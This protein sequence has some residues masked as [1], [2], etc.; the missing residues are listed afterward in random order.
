[1]QGYTRLALADLQRVTDKRIVCT[2]KLHTKVTHEYIVPMTRFWGVLSR[3]ELL[4][5]NL[6][7]VDCNDECVCVYIYR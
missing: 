2:W 3:T 6:P 1:M 7:G 4:K 5:V